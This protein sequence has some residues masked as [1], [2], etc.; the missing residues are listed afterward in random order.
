MKKN[1]LIVLI[2]LGCFAPSCN[3]LDIV[4]K[5]RATEEDFWKNALT[6]QR[7]LFSCY[8]YRP[9]IDYGNL[10][11]QPFGGDDFMR[12]CKTTTAKASYKSVMYNEESPTTVYH[13]LMQKS[14]VATGGSTYFLYEGIRYCYYL[15]ANVDKVPD[16]SDD[17]KT[18]WKGEMYFLIGLYHWYL[19]EYYGPIVLTKELVSLNATAEEMYL[20]RSPFDE[21]VDFIAECYDKA[22]SMLPPRQPDA[23]WYGRACATAAYGMKTRLLLFAASPL[24]NGNT[25]YY[26]NFKN[27]DGTQ[28]INQTY[29]PQKWKRAMDAAE[30]A[31]IYCEKNGYS[32]YT[33]PANSSLPDFERGKRDFHDMFVEPHFN[34]SEYLFT[35][36]NNPQWESYQRYSAIRSEWPY[37]S[38][39]FHTDVQ[40]LFPAVEMYYTK[41]GLPLEDDPLTKNVNLYTYNPAT[42]VAILNENREPRFYAC[43]TYNRGVEEINSTTKE[44]KGYAGEM[45]GFTL[46]SSGNPDI[47]K[48]YNCFTGYFSIKAIHR[49][50]SYE[51]ST[52]H[53]YF[54]D[55]SYPV[56]RL[57]E[58]Y[59]SYAEADFEYNGSLSAKSLEYLNKVRKRC[60]LPNF[61]DS[62]SLAGGIPTGAKLRKVLHQERSI[63]FLFEGHRYR[64]MRRWME[65]E[66]CMNS[67]KWKNWNVYG[68][69]ADSYYK[70][71]GFNDVDLHGTNVTFIAPKHYLLPIPQTEMEINVNLVQNPG[72]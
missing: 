70:I 53:F 19:L 18:M 8:V 54:H 43:V 23:R 72:Y 34:E 1:I 45:H 15:L 14:G 13:N 65:A 47:T 38:R 46:D 66:E 40:V 33:N 49:D 36:A 62:W 6:A 29:D 71:I 27:P 63:E 61:E 35:K 30:E 17:E 31:I 59:L 41:N 58:L 60:G 22:I 64:D 4:P 3:Y 5:D 68:T 37:S 9:E 28:L 69:D 26:S 16:L 67:S 2:A 12:S 55:A 42:E 57:A 21:C 25:K 56:V 20:P 32:L 48:E 44:V 10:P 51:S 50:I 39:G 24:F 52:D 11:G 7:F